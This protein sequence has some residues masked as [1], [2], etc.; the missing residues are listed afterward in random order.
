MNSKFQTAYESVFK[1]MMNK[2]IELG[3]H[4]QFTKFLTDFERGEMD[5]I[6]TVFGH[7]KVALLNL[8]RPCKVVNRTFVSGERVFIPLHPINSPPSTLERPSPLLQWWFRNQECHLAL[9]STH[10]RVA[11][12]TTRFAFQ[13]F[14]ERYA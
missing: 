12:T 4:L 8:H 11:T 14:C 6:S 7:E 5:A 9:G 1:A 3:C 13:L 10:L 2:W